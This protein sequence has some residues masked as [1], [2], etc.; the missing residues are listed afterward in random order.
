MYHRSSKW[1][2]KVRESSHRH[3]NND[4]LPANFIASQKRDT[5]P[6][7]R[8]ILKGFFHRLGKQYSDFL[9][10][11]TLLILSDSV[12]CLSST[13]T[14][15]RISSIEL[16][17]GEFI[18]KQIC[19]RSSCWQDLSSDHKYCTVILLS[20]NINLM[21]SSNILFNSTQF[22][23]CWFYFSLV[24]AYREGVNVCLFF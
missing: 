14:Y 8:K 10:M 13:H 3:P 22:S 12:I 9:T 16:R 24:F 11:A 4:F 5:E 1:R 20:S 18:S 2:R 7:C 21:K 19:R 6:F 17:D 15:L 23:Y